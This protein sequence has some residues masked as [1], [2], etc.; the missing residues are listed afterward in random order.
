MA[1]KNHTDAA[2]R[3]AA[4]IIPDFTAR[5]GVIFDAVFEIQAATRVLRQHVL[6]ADSSLE[7]APFACGVLWRI[8]RLADAI[9][10]VLGEVEL[11]KDGAI[12]AQ[13]RALVGAM[14]DKVMGNEPQ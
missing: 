13:A 7:L 8:S 12:L 14:P 1:T 9:H 3:P 2:D 5:V 11:D 4:D 6:P 10:S